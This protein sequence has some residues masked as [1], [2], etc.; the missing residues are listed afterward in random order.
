MPYS[1][2]QLR[3]HALPSFIDLKQPRKTSQTVCEG[4]SA[5]VKG[6][7]FQFDQ[8]ALVDKEVSE[9]WVADVGL[10]LEDSQFAH[11]VFITSQVFHQF[12]DILV[13]LHD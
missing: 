2:N 8:T 11:A 9:G 5:C 6:E 13:L 1:L 12:G 4:I 3:I 7:V 10:E